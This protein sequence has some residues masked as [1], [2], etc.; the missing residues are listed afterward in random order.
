[1]H[2]RHHRPDQSLTR[3]FNGNRVNP[4]GDA[5]G[6]SRR[7]AV[8]RLLL[9]AVGFYR[10]LTGGW[11]REGGRKTAHQQARGSDQEVREEAEDDLSS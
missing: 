7:Q 8:S 11:G 6:T 1:M 3:M 9:L 5:A 10:E 4:P 2:T